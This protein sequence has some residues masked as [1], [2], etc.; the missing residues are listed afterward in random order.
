MTKTPHPVFAVRGIAALTAA[1]LFAT[2]AC[3]D[4]SPDSAS[5]GGDPSAVMPTAAPVPSGEVTG[6]GMVI[7]QGAGTSL[8]LGPIAESYPPQ[9][10]G[11]PLE[12]WDWA[13][14]D[15]FEDAGGVKFATYAVTGTFDGTT[16]TVT[17]EPISGALYDPMPDPAAG[18]LQSTPCPEPEGGWEIVNRARANAQA[19]ERAEQSAIALDG[20]ATHWVD[21]FS[22]LE[23]SSGETEPEPDPDM[24][25]DPMM[26]PLQLILNVQ[27]SGD[28]DD[29]TQSL[30]TVWGGALCVTNP[31]HEPATL[32]EIAT[33]LRDLPGVLGT[34][35]MNDRVVAETIYDDG[36]L[37]DYADD[38]YGTDTV[39]VTSSLRDSG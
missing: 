39:V 16:M 14:R 22:G 15:D 1:L 30:R 36:S 26:D 19:L 23:I 31:R 32:E 21:Q 28:V 12:G 25:S 35:A 8:C 27:V 2:A 38:A 6:L 18:R 20:Y 4:T 33:S 5:D 11:I 7:D 3:G 10:E 34:Y 9:C 13:A 17:Q 24:G 29:A 37:Q